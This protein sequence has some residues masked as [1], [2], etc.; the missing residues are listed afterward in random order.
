VFLR[1]PTYGTICAPRNTILAVDLWLKL[2]AMPLRISFS[3]DWRENK[4][5][6]ISNIDETN[7]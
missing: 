3:Q 6:V 4:L 7:L 2:G 1:T 5:R